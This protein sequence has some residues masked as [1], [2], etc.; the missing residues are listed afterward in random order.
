MFPRPS[1]WLWW[2]LLELHTAFQGH[3][4]PFSK[5]AGAHGIESSVAS[6]TEDEGVC[7]DH[8]V[9]DGLEYVATWNSAQMPSED[10]QSVIN[11]LKSNSKQ[12]PQFS[13]L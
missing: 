9:E 8:S 7:R 2:M 3:D 1:I 11:G 12:L 4:I 6:S 13:K 10:L 5:T